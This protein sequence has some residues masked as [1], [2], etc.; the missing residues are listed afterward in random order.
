MAGG[1]RGQTEARAVLVVDAAG[2]A[3]DA[4]ARLG[5]LGG[6]ARLRRRHRKLVGRARHLAGGRR[7]TGPPPRGADAPAGA[8]S[9]TARPGTMEP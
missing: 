6:V 4:Q 2:A 7:G 1:A 8:S 9:A 5:D 3:A